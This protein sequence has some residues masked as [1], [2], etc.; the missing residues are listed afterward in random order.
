MSVRSKVWYLQHLSI[1]FIVH[2]VETHPLLFITQYSHLHMGKVNTNTSVCVYMH[3]YVDNYMHS[4]FFLQCV[5]PLPRKKKYFWTHNIQ[6]IFTFI[7]KSSNKS[8]ATLANSPCTAGTSLGFSERIYSRRTPWES[9]YPI[10]SHCNNTKVSRS[11]ITKWRIAL[12]IT[13]M[14]WCILNKSQWRQMPQKWRQRNKNKVKVQKCFNLS[15]WDA[16]RPGSSTC[17]ALY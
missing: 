17:N 6:L 5:P 14:N 7:W 12:I 1:R 10:Q 13:H 2:L 15:C 4:F 3:I 11:N 9:Y 16:L 8:M